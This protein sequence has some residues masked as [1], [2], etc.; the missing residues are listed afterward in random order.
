MQGPVPSIYSALSM[1]SLSLCDCQGLTPFTSGTLGYQIMSLSSGEGIA[2]HSS[3]L[4]WRITRTKEPG[5]IQ[6]MRITKTQKRQ[7][8]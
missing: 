8:D 5:G 1:G 7:A 4:A 2:T 6:S 3:I